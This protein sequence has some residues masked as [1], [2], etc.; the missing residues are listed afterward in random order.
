[1]TGFQLKFLPH[2][3]ERNLS[4]EAVNRN[5]A[6]GRMC[7]DLFACRE[8]KTDN[9]HVVRLRRRVSLLVGWCEEQG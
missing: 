4:F 5:L 7:G 8:N 9:F 2:R 1:M 3:G 6:G